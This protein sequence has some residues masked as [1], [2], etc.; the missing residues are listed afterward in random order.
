[1]STTQE[2]LTDPAL[3]SCVR[4][5]I[6]SLN[7][8]PIAM[9]LVAIGK[10]VVIGMQ[11]WFD[12]AQAKWSPGSV[13]QEHVLKWAFENK[14]DLDFGPGDSKYKSNWT[15]GPGYTCTDIRIAK[16][17]RGRVAVAARALQRS[18]ERFRLRSA[19]WPFARLSK[20]WLSTITSR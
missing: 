14:R 1:L 20:A 3:N 18:Y 8:K 6:L 10:R 11:S 5:F 15:G 16:S 9:N 13:L 12:L 19:A 2:I 17:R 7:G 4:L